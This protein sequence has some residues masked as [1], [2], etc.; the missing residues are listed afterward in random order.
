MNEVQNYTFETK[1]FLDYIDKV[2]CEYKSNQTKWFNKMIDHKQ[3]ILKLR[4][5]I[6]NTRLQKQVL[7]N[8]VKRMLSKRNDTYR[9]IKRRRSVQSIEITNIESSKFTEQY[10]L[11]V[12]DDI[13][14][15][16]S[17]TSMEDIPFQPDSQEETIDRKSSF[18]QR[19]GT[20]S[21]SFF[22]TL[23]T[24]KSP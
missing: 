23:S 24:N 5:Q 20:L 7:A 11:G 16:S 12:V 19:F 14:N 15:Q 9:L 21:G 6:K 22:K 8:T 13:P 10:S 18:F 3:R 17:D 2:E 4:R 1:K